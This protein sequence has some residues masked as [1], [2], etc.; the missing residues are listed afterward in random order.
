LKKFPDVGQ[1]NLLDIQQ[2]QSGGE[3][4]QSLYSSGEELLDEL[5][6]YRDVKHY[7]QLRY[8]SQNHEG[9]V[10]KIRFVLLPFSFVFLLAGQ[11]QYHIIW[12]TLDTEEATYIWH[13]G[14]DKT[15]LRNALKLIDE[16][17]GVIRTKGRQ[18]FL[19]N[20]PANFSRILHD[21]SDSKKGFI[22]WRDMLEE[23]L[24]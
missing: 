13:V 22:L 12:E 19:E 23:R 14:K 7:L 15:A 24:A 18:V 11:Q 5:L 10:L 1:P 3:D 9:G 6:K 16:E 2:V 21:Y 8:L 17:F 4:S 20:A